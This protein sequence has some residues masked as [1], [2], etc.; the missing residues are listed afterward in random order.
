MFVEVQLHHKRKGGHQAVC[1]RSPTLTPSLPSPLPALTA[2]GLRLPRGGPG[3]GGARL[4]PFAAGRGS[5]RTGAAGAALVHGGGCGGRAGRALQHQRA[6]RA[7]GGPGRGGTT[8]AGGA[9][10]GPGS[11]PAGA[12]GGGGAARTRPPS[13]RHLLAAPLE[14]GKAAGGRAGPAGLRARGERR[15]AHGAPQGPAILPPEG[16]GTTPA[17][18]GCSAPHRPRLGRRCPVMATSRPQQWPDPDAAGPGGPRGMT[19]FVVLGRA[20]HAGSPGP[21]PRSAPGT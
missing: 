11:W 8:G 21:A 5:G 17:P 2:F 16:S 12:T 14:P 3:R 13:W 4:L 20:G 7:S 19:G 6:P 9:G 1:P 15:A 10:G 18:T